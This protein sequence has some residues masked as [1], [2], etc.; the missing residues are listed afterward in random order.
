MALS[1]PGCTGRPRYRAPVPTEFGVASRP[2]ASPVPRAPRVARDSSHNLPRNAA[3]QVQEQGLRVPGPQP[4][5]KFNPVLLMPIWCRPPSLSANS[6]RKVSS[7]VPPGACA[8]PRPPPPALH[9]PGPTLGSP[10]T[11]LHTQ[12][13]N[14]RC[15]PNGRT[16]IRPQPGPGQSALVRAGP[17]SPGPRAPRQRALLDQELTAR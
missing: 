7:A 10:D 5:G 9:C 2:R 1:C 14:S 6:E 13:R 12:Q 4:N 17:P 8:G 3:V 15:D 11:A 16:C